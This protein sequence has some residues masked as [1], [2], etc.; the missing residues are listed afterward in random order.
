MLKSR[1]KCRRCAIP[2]TAFYEWHKS[3]PPGKKVLTPYLVHRNERNPSSDTQNSVTFLAGIY[4][5]AR[6]EEAD[7]YTFVIVT[8][9]SASDFSW[10]HSRQ[11]VFLSTERHFNLWLDPNVSAEDAVASLNAESG[12]VCVRMLKDLS[13]PAPIGAEKKQQDIFSFFRRRSPP[14]S[15]PANT[16]LVSENCKEPEKQEFIVQNSGKD[17]DDKSGIAITKS[18][19]KGSSCVEVTLKP[20]HS[21]QKKN[22]GWSSAS[23]HRRKG[24]KQISSFFC[25]KQE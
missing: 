15:N 9:A 2:I 5:K 19:E 12:L 11:P 17:R 22:K 18:L 25:K 7:N 16:K 8:T 23:P 21:I 4:E 24:Q 13:A 20:A 14:K 1:D 3:P 6:A 10:L